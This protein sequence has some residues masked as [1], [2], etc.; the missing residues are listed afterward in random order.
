VELGMMY[1]CSARGKGIGGV[2]RQRAEDFSVE[3]ITMEGRM[4][5]PELKQLSRGEG[6]YTLVLLSKTSRDLLPL[7][8][9]ISRKLHAEVGFAGIKD[10]RATSWQLISISRPLLQEDMPEIRNASLSVLGTSRWAVLP[11]ELRGNRFTIIVRAMESD[12]KA[13]NIEMP[14]CFPGYFG[15]QRFGTTRPNTHKVGRMLVKGEYEEAVR[16]FLS[17]AYP[18][19]P[20]QIRDARLS[21]KETWDLERSYNEFPPSLNYEKAVIKKLISNPSDYEGALASLPKTL[22]RFF[23]DA[24][25]S[26]L[27]NRA[28]S[29]RWALYGLSEVMDGDFVSPLDKWGSPSRPIKLDA[30]NTGSLRRMI[31]NGKA[32]PMLRVLGEKTK[33]EG[34]DLEIYGKIL[35]DEGITL[36]DF[37]RISGHQ[38]LGTLRFATFKPLE[39]STEGPL[40]DEL[41]PGMSK[42]ALRTSL[43]KSCYATVVL[44]EIMR[45]EDPFIAGF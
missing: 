41:N 10:R 34:I 31:M 39:L 11:G 18:H 5:N 7:V 13:S 43:P 38:V 27:F 23:V 9:E 1:Y 28:L 2:L 32:V 4:V 24:Y 19:E 25:Q 12:P 22:Q 42:I 16:E 44:R 21:L 40:P 17:E 20:A 26:Y 45:P 33:L 8:S 30:H 36:S 3:E 37:G 29:E 35:K 15:H 6:N 14:D